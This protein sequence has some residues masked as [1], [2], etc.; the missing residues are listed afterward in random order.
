M[1]IWSARTRAIRARSP[2]STPAMTSEWPDR[3]FVADSATRSAPSSSGRQRYGEANVLSTM[4][5]APW[6]W[7]MAA[8][9]ARSD[10][11]I[12]G[13]EIVSA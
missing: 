9:A 7:A 12:V 3:Y 10:T 6:R 1:S 4:R 2:T 11:T 5:A 13:L 8:S